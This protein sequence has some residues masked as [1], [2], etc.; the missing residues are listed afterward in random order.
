ML[1]AA[2][3]V[4]NACRMNT[5]WKIAI[6][7]NLDALKRVVAMLVA[8][9]GSAAGH[10]G[11]AILPRHLHRVAL[12][13]LRPAESAARRLIIVAARGLVV[14]IR[15]WRQQRPKAA[16]SPDGAGAGLA[17]SS[18]AFVTPAAGPHRR[19]SLSLL[20]PLKREATT[21]LPAHSTA[22]GRLSL[23]DASDPAASRLGQ[24]PSPV[25][26]PVDPLDAA[27]LHRRLSALASALDDLPGQAVRMARWQARRHFLLACSRG[28]DA[29]TSQEAA[30]PA[31]APDCG[32][33]ARRP[34]RPQPTHPFPS[35][36]ILRRPESEICEVLT[37]VHG[38]AVRVRDG[39]PRV[40]SMTTS[41]RGRSALSAGR[42]CVR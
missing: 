36:A 12:S 33:K 37:T 25:P 23:R 1:P 28:D 16:R 26:T 29:T 13:L 34:K 5:D 18:P 21:E 41:Y 14:D 9:I 31:A 8:M 20:D 6:G 27:C 24:S 7:K 3:E 35:R 15:P 30:V 17:P 2:A 42:I 4:L 38:S 10:Q 32:R 19:M 22:V 39:P 40:R 11:S